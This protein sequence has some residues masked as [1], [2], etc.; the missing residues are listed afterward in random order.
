MKYKMGK[1]KWEFKDRVS[2]FEKEIE[3]PAPYVQFP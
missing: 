3:L 2:I 1:Q